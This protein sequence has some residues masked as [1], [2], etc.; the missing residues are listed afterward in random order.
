MIDLFKIFGHS[1]VGLRTRTVIIVV[2]VFSMGIYATLKIT[3][4]STNDLIEEHRSTLQKQYSHIFAATYRQWLFRA[5]E[6]ASLLGASSL[7]DAMLANNPAGVQYTLENSVNSL[8]LESGA[9]NVG[10][11]SVEGN[12]LGQ[13][14][15]ERGY[16]SPSAS[17]VLEALKKGMPRHLIECANNDC[18]QYVIVP[19]MVRGKNAGVIHI[20]LHF[21]DVFKNFF[22]STGLRPYLIKGRKLPEAASNDEWIELT[23]A[24]VNLPTEYGLFTKIDTSI[25]HRTVKQ[26][27]SRTLWISMSLAVISGALLIWPIWIRL[28]RL[29]RLRDKLPLLV[30]DE[31]AVAQFALTFSPPAVK[32]EIDD[33]STALA[34]FSKSLERSLEN[35]IRATEE[36]ARRI[37]AEDFVKERQEMLINM[38]DA[39]E[40]E[41]KNLALNLHDELGQWLVALRLR[42]E[43]LEKVILETNNKEAIELVLQIKVISQRTQTE[44]RKTMASLRP[45]AIDTVGLT[46]SLEDTVGHW[47]TSLPKVDFI[48][49]FAKDL[50]SLPDHLKI[51][52]YRLAQEGLTNIAKHADASTVGIK[53]GFIEKNIIGMAI[54]DNGRGFDVEAVKHGFGL[55]GMKDRTLAIGGTFRVVSSPGNGTRIEICLPTDGVPIITQDT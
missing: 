55:D 12:I 45:E 4:W 21:N 3:E 54:D 50:D 52:I 5:E 42:A 34:D 10:V 29:K 13:I 36:E 6:Q 53:V 22:D 16:S 37:A 46:K 17:L 28:G 39:M 11:F 38:T 18:M 51:S 33:L 15:E 40:N 27:Q 41:R 7:G 35:E 24:I 26:A 19:L 23:P 14:S 49:R 2:I 32:D 1:Y 31:A 20:D 44:L 48:T 30:G 47:R 9:H 25:E 43:Q 8:V